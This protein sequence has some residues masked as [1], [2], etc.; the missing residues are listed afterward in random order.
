V[1]K[2]IQELAER[3]STKLFNSGGCHIFAVTLQSVRPDEK[4]VLVGV[5]RNTPNGEIGIHHLYARR[6]HLIVD[7]GG[8]K[9][10]NDYLDWLRAAYN[11]GTAFTCH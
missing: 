7:I 9:G 5:F 11:Q 6:G 8:I 3:D 4:Y 1:T 10:E 2:I